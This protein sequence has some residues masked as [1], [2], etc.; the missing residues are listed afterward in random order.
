MRTV[1]SLAGRTSRQDEI[2]PCG[3]LC[4]SAF[5]GGSNRLTLILSRHQA[6]AGCESRDFT[7]GGGIEQKILAD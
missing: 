4:S 3:D 1:E 2:L 6:R 7:V 5:I